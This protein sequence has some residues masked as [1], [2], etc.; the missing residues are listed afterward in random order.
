LA[1][2]FSASLCRA[3]D[4]QVLA[5]DAA[6]QGGFLRFY[7]D[8][9]QVEAFGKS[10]SCH[11]APGQSYNQC[12]IGVPANAPAGYQALKIY[13]RGKLEM[14]KTVEIK[15]TAFPT[16]TLNLSKEKKDLLKDSENKDEEIKFIRAALST[17]N[18]KRLWEGSF[19]QPVKGKI[20]SLYGERRI[21]DG[22]VRPNYYHRGL[23]LGSP[24]GTKMF[25][26]NAGK[27]L[28][29]RHFTEEGNMVMLDHGQGVISLY[30]HCS[31][32]AVKEGQTVAKGQWIGNVGDTGVANTP[33]VHF[34][35]Y[36][37]G[38]P[39]DPLYWIKNSQ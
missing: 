34:G 22:E 12:L 15:E 7:A 37:H 9:D 17:E 16:E 39:I 10:L 2:F 27:V 29:A 30:M 18:P 21:L 35:I 1:F 3:E 26:S 24:K 23:D 19:V 33:H 36:I 38:T 4:V 32:M 28:T 11:R 8:V 13:K 5:R 14:E 6:P 20:E 31:S 25:A